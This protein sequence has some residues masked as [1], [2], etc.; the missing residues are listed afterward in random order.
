MTNLPNPTFYESSKLRGIEHL[1]IKKFLS[2]LDK[3]KIFFIIV[4]RIRLIG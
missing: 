3:L 4:D 2:P 1:E